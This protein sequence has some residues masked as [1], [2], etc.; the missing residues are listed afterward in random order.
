MLKRWRLFPRTKIRSGSLFRWKSKSAAAQFPIPFSWQMGGAGGFFKFFLVTVWR[1][2]CD[3]STVKLSTTVAFCDMSTVEIST[4]YLSTVYFSTPPK[5]I[6]YWKWKIC[7]F[8]A[9]CHR[10][11]KLKFNSGFSIWEYFFG[12]PRWEEDR[13]G[14]SRYLES[15]PVVFI[16]NCHV[17]ICLAM[18]QAFL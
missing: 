6:E 12:K 10:L 8:F 11:L 16:R 2:S 17:C 4:V 5:K 15:R 7:G 13:F 3:K 18:K 1:Q 14:G 9:D